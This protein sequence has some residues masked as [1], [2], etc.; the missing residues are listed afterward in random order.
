MGLLPMPLLPS[1]YAARE[2]ARHSRSVA[3][4]LLDADPLARPATDARHP[5]ATAPSPTHPPSRP[6]A[7]PPARQVWRPSLSEQRRSDPA[8]VG[9][10][11]ERKVGS[12]VKWRL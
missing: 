10:T 11:W 7:T 8:G 6:P 5:P 1:E 12:C 4:R 2:A 3:E 9:W